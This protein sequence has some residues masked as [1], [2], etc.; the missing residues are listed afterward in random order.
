M[1]STLMDAIGG[2]IQI[3]IKDCAGRLQISV[4]TLLFCFFW[5]STEASSSER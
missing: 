1:Q 4:I 3:I 2:Y 5:S